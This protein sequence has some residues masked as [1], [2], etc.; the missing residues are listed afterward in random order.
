MHNDCSLHAHVEGTEVRR[1]GDYGIPYVYDANALQSIFDRQRNS[2]V[3]NK[4]FFQ[5]I[6]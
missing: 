2:T 5:R 1:W 6:K 3:K 4:K